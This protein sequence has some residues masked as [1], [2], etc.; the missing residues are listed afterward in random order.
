MSPIKP[1]A[2]AQGSP[3]VAGRDRRSVVAPCG[4]AQLLVAVGPSVS[5]QLPDRGQLVVVGCAP[6]GAAP[7]CLHGAIQRPHPLRR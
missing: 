5:F 7:L 4:V 6:G 3:P 2:S 1:F